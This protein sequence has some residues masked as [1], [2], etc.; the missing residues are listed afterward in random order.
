MRKKPDKSDKPDPAQVARAEALQKQIDEIVAGKAE[1]VSPRSLKDFID[2]KGAELAR[3]GAT[4]K[5]KR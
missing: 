3:K 4:R 2:Q 5:K 1:P